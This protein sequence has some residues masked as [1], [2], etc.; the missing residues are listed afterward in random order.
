MEPTTREFDLGRDDDR[1]V[2]PA[3]YMEGR[4]YILINKN[5]FTMTET[6]TTYV[7]EEKQETS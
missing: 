4:M 5:M 6:P 7:L 1:A 2:F 3:R